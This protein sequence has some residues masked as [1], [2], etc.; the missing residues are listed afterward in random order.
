[1]NPKRDSS[2]DLLRVFA[3]IAVIGLHVLRANGGVVAIHIYHICGFAVPLFFVISGY[4]LLDREIS[5]CYLLTKI[6]GIVK[7]VTIWNIIVTIPLT[8]ANI[9]R[10]NS[11]I[12]FF[13]LFLRQCINS[14]TQGESVL[15][16]FWYFLALLIVYIIAFV[17]SKLAEESKTL[18]YRLISILWV[19]SLVLSVTIQII[20]YI[21]KYPVQSAIIQ[22][23]RIWTWI[24]YFL[25]GSLLKITESLWNNYKCRKIYFGTFIAFTVLSICV[26]YLG[27]GILNELH[28]EFF[29][30]DF[31]IICWVISIFVFVKSMNIGF[32]KWVNQI[33]LITLGT[34]I[35]HTIVRKVVIHFWEPTNTFGLLLIWGIVSCITV[36]TC[37]VINKMP[38]LKKLINM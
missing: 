15:F 37:L 14:V 30:D 25:L 18:K 23:M 5:F 2:I 38:G 4:L 36:V 11:I 8:V 12:S 35:L 7:L 6:I 17:I 3:A 1:M 32:I 16:Q 22:P 34:F 21:N 26:E 28:S 24:Q 20:S 9:I 13:P 10:G 31:A 27:G 19:S 29:Y 33:A